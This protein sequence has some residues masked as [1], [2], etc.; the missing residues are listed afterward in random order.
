MLRLFRKR[1]SVNNWCRFYC[2]RPFLS[3]KQQLQSIG[4]RNQQ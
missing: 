2:L 3:P 1:I 4:E